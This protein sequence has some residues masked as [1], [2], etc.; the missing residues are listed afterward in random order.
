MG[1]GIASSKSAILFALNPSDVR[2]AE[3]H[4]KKSIQVA[5]A[6]NARALNYVRP[7]LFQNSGGCKETMMKPVRCWSQFTVG[8]TKGL[9]RLTSGG[10]GTSEAH[11]ADFRR[12]IANAPIP[13]AVTFFAAVTLHGSYRAGSL[14][15]AVM[16]TRSLPIIPRS[17]QAFS[18]YCSSVS[19]PEACLAFSALWKASKGPR[20]SPITKPPIKT[21][22]LA[23]AKV[24]SSSVAMAR[25]FICR[26]ASLVKFFR[27]HPH[28]VPASHEGGEGDGKLQK[29]VGHAGRRRLSRRVAARRIEH[30]I[31]DAVLHHHLKQVAGEF[32]LVH[33]E[34]FRVF[35]QQ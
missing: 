32:G 26:F 24:L 17:S 14:E 22:R 29:C 15:T 20:L 5:R 10:R 2:E 16:T 35:A 25:V 6:Q 9:K 7:Q 13:D 11:C 4:L 23:A 31:K 28:G 8:F 1:S 34:G 12:A 33:A 18:V 21:L 19:S 30:G 27:R 3:A